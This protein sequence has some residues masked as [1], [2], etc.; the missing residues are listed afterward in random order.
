M[1]TYVLAAWGEDKSQPSTCRVSGGDGTV[2]Q[3][4]AIQVEQLIL[5]ITWMEEIQFIWN[6]L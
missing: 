3:S 6:W 5:Y 4:S 2:S 1:N